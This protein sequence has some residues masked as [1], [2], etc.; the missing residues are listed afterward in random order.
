MPQPCCVRPYP[1]MFYDYYGFPE[2]AYSITYPAPGNPSLAERIAE[3]L[4]A[5]GHSLPHR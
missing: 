2:A 1:P 4:R 3:L 5:G